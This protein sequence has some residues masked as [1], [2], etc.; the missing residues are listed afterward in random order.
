MLAKRK[1]IGRRWWAALCHRA[2]AI[3]CV[4]AL[5]GAPYGH[6]ESAE[7]TPTVIGHALIAMAPAEAPAG[8]RGAAPDHHCMHHGQCSVPAVL[9]GATQIATSGALRQRPSGNVLAASR[10]ISPL[11]HPPKARTIL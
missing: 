9:P 2:G 1:R 6:I 8:H 7:A 3:A 10:V 11:R 5:V 4:L